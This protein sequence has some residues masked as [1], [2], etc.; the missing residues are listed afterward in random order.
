LIINYQQKFHLHTQ[1]FHFN[2]F[3]F[4]MV[5]GKVSYC[6]LLLCLDKLKTKGNHGSEMGLF[7]F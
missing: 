5:S 1:V 6:I 4:L 3:V 7:S 2:L